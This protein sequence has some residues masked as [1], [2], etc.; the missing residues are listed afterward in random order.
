MEIRLRHFLFFPAALV[1]VLLAEYVHAEN[2]PGGF[3]EKSYQTA[4]RAGT[5]FGVFGPMARS[6]WFA[7]L[8]AFVPAQR[9][10]FFFPPPYNTQ[11]VRL[12]LPAD[13]AGTD[14]VQAV[15]YSYW[16][17]MNNHVGSNTMYI[18]L[19]LVDHGGPTL[20]AYDKT[21]DAVSKSGPVFADGPFRYASTEAWY[22]SARQP[23][24]LYMW[25]PMESTLHRFDIGTK[26]FETVFDIASNTA[27]FGDSAIWQVHSSD[28]DGVHSFTVIDKATYESLG[29]GVYKESAAQ[30]LYYPASRNY[31]ECQVDKSGRWLVI[32]TDVDGIEG[33]DN[34]IIDL[35]TGA[36]K[37]LLDPDGAPGHSDLGFG[38]MVGV[39]NWADDGYSI[40]LW[41]LSRN[42]MKGTGIE[43]Y[44]SADWYAGWPEHISHLNARPGVPAAQQYACGSSADGSTNARSNELVCFRL[45]GSYDTLVVAPIMTDWGA[46][47]GGGDEYFKYPKANIDVTGQYAIWTSNTGGNR[48]DAFLAK[49]PA[50]LLT[51]PRPPP[52]DTVAPAVVLAAPAGG[53]TVS[54]SAVVVSA[55]A[56]DNVHVAGVQFRL[57]GSNLGAEDSVAPY[58]FT[59][60]TTLADDGPHVLTA[61]ARDAAGNASES[62]AVNVIVH[63]S[64]GVD[65]AED[66]AWTGLV[67]ATLTG[68]V[69]QKTGGCDGCG[70]SGAVSTQVITSGNGFVQVEAS[71]TNTYRAFGLSQG[72]RNMETEDIDFALWL[73]AG[74]FV[75]VREGGVYKADT[76]FATGDE[77]RVAVVNKKIRYS[78]NR[79]VFHKSDKTSSLPLSANTALGSPGATIRN[80][81]IA[82]TATSP[83]FDCDAGE[84]GESDD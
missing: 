60:D 82:H 52:D 12:T 9:G 20:F 70:D 16:A 50:H 1:L 61:V 48:L 38:Y 14:C 79:V 56:S 23:M 27:L 65:S 55:H 62:P 30:F 83:A 67:N 75:E 19:N 24:K 34:H 29:C 13:C 21:T 59:W 54:C 40:K 39:D 81:V 37:P 76:T 51:A 63:N 2:F 28:D 8:A 25:L 72:H 11:G 47:G 44:R 68:R 33:D 73:S 46:P 69:L 3:V 35:E 5:A 42:P 58:S 41:D 36:A 4:R 64:A 77:L 84:S 6:R 15:G 43:V 18:L 78:K 26:T 22:F 57:D 49:I 66:V 45:D 10:A 71:E 31:D 53:A 32:K 17:L 7:S 80:A 74:G